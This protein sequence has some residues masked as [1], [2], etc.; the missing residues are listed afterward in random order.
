MK[1]IV[2]PYEI[3]SRELGGAICLAKV[4][5]QNGWTV[6][7]G[8][9]QE[10]FPFIDNFDRSVW[11]L[12]SIV[13]GELK[14]LKKV[15]TKHFIATS[16]PEGLTPNPLGILS[17]PSRFSSNTIKLA[18][19]IFFWGK[20]YYNEFKKI[21]GDYE[22]K[23]F[24]VGS[25]IF[26]Y[27]K[28]KVKE[29]KNIT[30]KKT[31]LITSSFSLTNTIDGIDN[32]SL[33]ADNYKDGLKK[34]HI[35]LLRLQTKI[36]KKGLNSYIKLLEQMNAKLKKDFKIIFRPH[37]S[38]NINYWEKICKKLTNIKIEINNTENVLDQISKSTFII[39]FGSTLTHQIRLA[40]KICIY[41]PK[42]KKSI[43]KS[44][45]NED[46]AN[47]SINI[48]DPNELVQRLNDGTLKDLK[49]KNNLEFIIEDFHNDDILNS[50][51]KI[52]QTID[53]KFTHIKK[54]NK[55][56]FKSNFLSLINFYIYNFKNIFAKF[57]AIYF[58]FIPYIRNRFGLQLWRLNPKNHYKAKKLTLEQ[59]REEFFEIKDITDK[60]KIIFDRHFSGFFRIY[61]KK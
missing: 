23:L 46:I 22:N 28:G 27:W 55:D 2:I 37:P 11:F 31:I 38:E 53:K 15:K 3:Q 33:M 29:K 41:F 60:N 14:F 18:D 25:Q 35:Q 16:D 49:S 47:L 43:L 40:N 21:Y 12:K 30:E 9:K 57:L 48:E 45:F 13:P 24:I 42:L 34:E 51:K 54:K 6:Y 52:F 26:D 4:F 1:K 7:I 5:I 44:C 61:K 20:S 59:F 8:Q 36:Q 19:V 32:V 56:P 50:S 17:I 10:L 39:N 58:S